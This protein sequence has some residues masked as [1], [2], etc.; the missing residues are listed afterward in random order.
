MTATPLTDLA[1]VVRSKNAGPTLLTIDLF[2]RDAAAFALAAGSPALAADGVAGLYGLA[3]G[4]VARHDLPELW[5][6]KFTLPRTVVAGSPGDGDV[7]GAQQHGP[8]LTVL[9]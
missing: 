7:Y 2:F 5:A 3:A 6:L 9:L 8:F 4:S 1:T